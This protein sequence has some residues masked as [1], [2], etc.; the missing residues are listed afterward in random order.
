M[1]N[2]HPKGLTD[3]QGGISFARRRQQLN[4]ISNHLLDVNLTQEFRGWWADDTKWKQEVLC[5][6]QKW[7]LCSKVFTTKCRGDDSF[8]T[9]YQYIPVKKNVLVQS[10]EIGL[11]ARSDE[12]LLP[13]TQDKEFGLY[14]LIQTTKNPIHVAKLT[15]PTELDDWTRR[16]I[17]YSSPAG[18]RI[19]EVILMIYCHDYSGLVS[20][21]DVEVIPGPDQ[22]SWYSFASVAA[23]NPSEVDSVPGQ[24]FETTPEISFSNAFLSKIDSLR[25]RT[26]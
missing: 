17:T 15:F 22:D 21:T 2:F 3:K 23:S 11:R 24:E 9:I 13:V 20:F 16:S 19:Q 25:Q 10:L 1:S 26:K 6:P 7:L 8:K 12:Y 5:F 18:S 14:A 4:L